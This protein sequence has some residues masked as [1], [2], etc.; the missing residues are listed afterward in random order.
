MND[1]QISGNG[2]QPGTNMSLKLRAALDY[3]GDKLTTH[4]A[5][6]FKPANQY[7]LDEWLATRRAILRGS[8]ISADRT[9][10]VG[11]PPGSQTS[12]PMQHWHPQVVRSRSRRPIAMESP[13]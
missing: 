2:L 7:L 8:L 3:L 11:I 13:N 10:E 4:R 12:P 6:R 5:S 9:T 1:P